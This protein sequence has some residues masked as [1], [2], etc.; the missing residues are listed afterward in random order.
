MQITRID[1]ENKVQ[2]ICQKQKN[3]VETGVVKD[4]STYLQTFLL[5]TIV[6]I[7]KKAGN[8]NKPDYE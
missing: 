6:N 5:K 7:N 8:K 4:F 2:N 1:M 3:P